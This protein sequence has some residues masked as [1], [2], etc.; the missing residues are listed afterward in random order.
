MEIT[1]A[2]TALITG[3]NGGIGVAIARA[4]H[5]AGC[6]LVLSGRRADVLAP[7]AEALGARVIVADLARREDLD[8]LHAEA[9]D[10]DLAVFNAALPASGD[11][12]EYTVEQMD[13]ALD[14][15]L[16]APMISARV[17]G[18]GMA[19]RGRG[20]LVFIASIAGKVAMGNT[21][22]YSA[23]KFGMRGFAL[24]LR[25][26][27]R[28]RGVGVSTVFPGFIR[29]AGMFVNSG[30]TLP[31][32]L[33]TRAPEDVAAA[34]LRAVRDDVAEID[35]ASFEQSLAGRLFS[36]APALFSRLQGAVDDGSTARSVVDGQRGKR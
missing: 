16:R 26:D 12:M 18:E 31:R 1:P 13:R 32:V 34:V 6:K 24:G 21:A 11:V 36:V 15:N 14:V 23:T 10:I 29:D 19:R 17:L 22:V 8:R 3:A 35:V 4:L 7:V 25:D 2:T 9:G 30:A 28:T 20:H 33:G 27:L 5:R